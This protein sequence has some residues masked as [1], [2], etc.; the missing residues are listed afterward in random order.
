MAEQME[1]FRRTLERP[2]RTF[3]LAPDDRYVASALAFYL[4][5]HPRTFCWEDPV[6][7]ESQYGVWGRPLDRG[8]WDALVILRNPS[9]PT[10]TELAGLFGRWEQVGE[11]EIHLGRNGAP[12]ARDRRYTVFVGRDFR[13]VLAGEP[14]AKRG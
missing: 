11:I 4:P 3:L 12:A 5:D 2:D 1:P 8:G 7:P 13:P 9:H 6:H 10:R 14:P